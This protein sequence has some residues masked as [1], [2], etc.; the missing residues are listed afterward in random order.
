[1]IDG[2]TE[3]NLDK[4]NIN[5]EIRIGYLGAKMSACGAI[6][7]TLCVVHICRLLAFVIR[8][9]ET[10]EVCH[11]EEWLYGGTC[12]AYEAELKG[13]KYFW[14]VNLKQRNNLEGL[15]VDGRIILIDF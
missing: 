13:V 11:F 5:L 9:K 2:E 4:S 10:I 1:M 12:D 8:R 15:D 6:Y 14:W 3:V 7:N